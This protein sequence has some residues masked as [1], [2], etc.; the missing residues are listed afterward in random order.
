MVRFI[1]IYRNFCLQRIVLEE[2]LHGGDGVAAGQGEPRA[3]ADRA[4][5]QPIA[6]VL[7]PLSR[8][9]KCKNQPVNNSARQ[10]GLAA[11]RRA[12]L[13]DAAHVQGEVGGDAVQQG[14]V[15]NRQL[16]RNASP[17]PLQCS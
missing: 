4:A 13:A 8:N 11:V 17:R 2:V 12:C 3:Q 1:D 7:R 15:V 9:T 14:A 10:L 5:V 16:L 6:V